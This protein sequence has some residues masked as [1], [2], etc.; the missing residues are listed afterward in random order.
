MYQSDIYKRLLPHAITL[1]QLHRQNTETQELFIAALEDLR[2]GICSDTTADMIKSLNRPTATPNPLHLY[3]TNIE[4][5][6]HNAEQLHIMDGLRQEFVASDWGN[7]EKIQSPI[8]KRIYFKPGAPVI[9]VYNISEEIHN[10]TRATFIGKD[11]DDALV[12]IEGAKM[13]IRRATW[14]N[15][16]QEGQIIGSR[17]QIPMKL[18]WASTVNKVQG[19]EL[20]AVC[21]H[22]SYEFTGGLIYTALSRVKKSEDV[23]VRD[24]I[25]SHVKSRN[26][27]IEKM[28]SLH[29]EPFESDCSCCTPIVAPESQGPHHLEES[30]TNEVTDVIEH[31]AGDSEELESMTRSFMDASS[32]SV[33]D[34]TGEELF[35]LDLLLDSYDDNNCFASDPPEDFDFKE[36]LMSF[37][38][39]SRFAESA[40]FA[41]EK[42]ALIDELIA[43]ESKMKKATTYITIL[44]KTTS[45]KLQKFVKENVHDT[46]ISRVQFTKITQDVWRSNASKENHMMLRSLFQLDVK[47]RLTAPML[48]LGANLNY[49]VFQN[50][51][52]I[53]S[54]VLRANKTDLEQ[55]RRVNVADM[56]AAGRAKVRYIAGWMASC[57]MKKSRKYIDDNMYSQNSATR[58]RV[59][60]EVEKL[61]M[62]KTYVVVPYH[63]L[64][65]TTS[66]RATLDVIEARQ[67]RTHGLIHVSD[68]YFEAGKPERLYFPSLLDIQFSFIIYQT[69]SCP[70]PVFCGFFLSQYFQ[71][72]VIFFLFMVL[73]FHD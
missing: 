55:V 65:A 54:D 27:E 62:L 66:H 13:K 59:K 21:F 64:L 29:S 58:A 7:V 22:S 15:Y 51:I 42:N 35:D 31:V 40:G 72:L 32:S 57:V 43:C 47:D 39:T 19:Q 12:E 69:S 18:F 6:A 37:K 14:T 52:H 60:K 63:V 46:R 1:T 33:S 61:K 56:D 36:L 2:Y 3:L 9:I 48:S 44:W 17:C 38:D 50:I 24:F 41:Q 11:G 34:G 25:P 26:T 49:G 71:F 45:R 4:A 53:I 5:D 28:S 10:G 20:E 67:Y 23:E 70:K 68:A 16:N 30:Q 8:G 73:T